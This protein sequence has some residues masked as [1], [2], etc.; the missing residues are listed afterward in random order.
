V[1]EFGVSPLALPERMN[2]LGVGVHPINM[3]QALVAIERWIEHREKHYVC[4]APIHNVLACQ[5]DPELKRIFNQSGLTTPDGMPLVWMAWAKGYRRADRV[6]GPDLMESLCRRSVGPGYRHFLLGGHPGVAQQVEALLERRFPGLRVVGTLS[7]PFSPMTGDREAEML[8][9]INAASPD[10]VWV[11]LGSPRQEHWMA[12]C[13]A[14]LDATVLIGVGAAF[15]FLSGR[16]RQ[17]PR[18]MQR[19]GLEWLF[20]LASEPRRLWRRYLRYPIFF[21]LLGAQLVGLRRFELEITKEGDPSEPL[22]E[23][24]R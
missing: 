15:D 7:P 12:D 9:T 19:S 22:S 16:K 3:D 18:W 11:A 17:A 1:T 23:T 20:R 10:I 13:I 6:Y 5:D 8:A 4:L 24:G 21:L 2:I 14:S